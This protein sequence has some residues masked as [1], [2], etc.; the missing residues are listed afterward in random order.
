MTQHEEI[1]EYLKTHETITPM[2]AFSELGITKLATRIGELERLG[3]D[4]GKEWITKKRG[5]KTIQYMSYSLLN[6]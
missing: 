4:F 1:L 2:I 6:R 3:H 5:D